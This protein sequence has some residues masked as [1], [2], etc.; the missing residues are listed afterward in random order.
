MIHIYEAFDTEAEAEAF[1]ERYYRNFHPWGYGT[2]IKIYSPAEQHFND[3]RD[4][5]KWIAIG[6]RS[7]SC[8]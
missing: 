1:K 6:S 8:D 2:H 4:Q 5:G 7:A 3:R